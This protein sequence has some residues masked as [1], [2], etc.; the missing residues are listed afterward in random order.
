[1]AFKSPHVSFVSFAI[2]VTPTDTTDVMVIETD[3]HL[4][5]R[6]PAYND[7]ALHQLIAAAQHYLA[8]N[9]GRATHIRVISNRSGEI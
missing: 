4:N 2:E 5:S 3:L 9:A 8:A 6:H 7:R 1:M